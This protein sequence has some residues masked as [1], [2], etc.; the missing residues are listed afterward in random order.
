MAGPMLQRRSIGVEFRGGQP[1]EMAELDVGG[2]A[3]QGGRLAMVWGR[4]RCV[5]GREDCAGT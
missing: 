3:D 4:R 2:V 5:G 1:V